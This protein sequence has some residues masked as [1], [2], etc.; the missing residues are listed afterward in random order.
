MVAWVRSRRWRTLG[1][2]ALVV[3]GVLLF[4]AALTDYFGLR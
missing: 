1:G 2:W 4:V 3:V